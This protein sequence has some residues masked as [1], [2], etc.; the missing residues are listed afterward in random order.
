MPN[1]QA[2]V[3]ISG[4]NERE[5][6]VGPRP[7]ERSE[8][9][10]FFGRDREISELLSLVTSN[11]VVLCY[12]PSGAGKTSLINAGLHPR[13]ET[14]G[15]EVLPSTRVRGLLPEGVDQTS[16]ANIYIFNAVLS[17]AKETGSPDELAQ[18]TLAAYLST[19]PHLTDEEDFPSPRILIFDQF[20]ELLTSYLE[21]WQERD[22]FFHQVHAALQE[23]PLLRVLFVMR[24]D[25]VAR[26]EPF[27]RILKPLQQTRF[28]LDLLGPSGAQAAVTGPLRGT[29]RHFKPGVVDT[30][31][32]ELLKVRI[33]STAGEATE[34]IGEYVE[35][36]QLQV[37][38]RNLWTS[39][40]DEVQEISH[41]H[42]KAYG[43]VD[44]ALRE[45]YESCLTDA[46]TGLHTNEANLRQWF[47][48]QLITPAGTRGIVFRDAQQTAG[49]T[50]QVVDFLENRHII[51]GEW[52]AGSRWYELTH[53][54]LIKPIQHAN[55]RWRA[56]RQANRNRML[57]FAGVAMALV[58]M[59]FAATL[60]FRRGTA[61]AVPTNSTFVA[62]AN[63]NATS[64]V[65]AQSTTVAIESTSVAV[66]A[67]A[68]LSKSR[69]LAAE[70][71]LA[72]DRNLSLLLAIEANRRDDTLEARRSLHKVLSRQSYIDG[73]FLREL[74]SEVIAPILSQRL[75]DHQGPVVSV[76]FS[77]DSAR[78]VSGSG[79]GTLLV[80]DVASTETIGSPLTT[81]SSS[82]ESVA[83]SPN[84]RFVA[85]AGQDLQISL[86][87]AVTG[88]PVGRPMTGH[89]D[90]ITCLAFSPNGKLLASGSMDRHIFIWEV[91][92][93][94][95]VTKLKDVDTIASL[96]WSPDGRI[97]AA[98]TFGPTV[99]FWATDVW[100]FEDAL[101]GFSNP[102]RSMAWSPDGKLLALGLGSDDN[103]PAS[104]D[105]IL[106]DFENRQE[107][108]YSLPNLIQLFKTVGFR[109]IGEIAS[110]DW[111]E[112]STIDNTH[113]VRA[114]AFHPAGKILA[115]GRDDGTITFWDVQRGQILGTPLR[116]HD[117]WVMSIDFSP[118]GL[119]MLSG[120]IDRTVALWNLLAST[121]TVAVSPTGDLLAASQGSVIS[122][123]ETIGNS[124][125]P[126]KILS[127]H[128]A[129]VL[130]LAF[131]PDGNTLASSG[132]DNTI[133]LWNVQ[134]GLQI[135]AAL[136]TRSL[137]PTLQFNP[138]G[139]SLAL[140]GE[141]GRV[142]LMDLTTRIHQT[143]REQ[144][145]P[146]LKVQFTDGGNALQVVGKDGSLILFDWQT[147]TPQISMLPGTYRE[148]ISTAFSENGQK[149]A[150]FQV[151]GTGETA[152]LSD[153]DRAHGII[154]SY[155]D[156]SFDP[157]VNRE[158]ID[159]VIFK[160]TEGNQ[161]VDSTFEEYVRAS[162][163]IPMRGAFHFYRENLPWKEQA[164][165]F[166]S[167][168]DGQ[169]LHFYI[170][171]VE[172]L[173]QDGSTDFLADAE[174][175]LKYVDE[176]V[177]GRVML[178]TYNSYQEKLGTAGDWM[179]DWP[180]LILDYPTTPDR[181]GNPSLPR[182]FQDWHIWNY[183][184]K[185]EGA[186]YGV[187]ADRI[188]LAV[189]NGTPAE[190]GQ[191]LG[192]NAFTI[193]DRTSNDVINPKE[194]VQ[195]TSPNGLAFSPDDAYLAAAGRNTV[196][197]LNAASGDAISSLSVSG[198][199]L[200]MAF[201]PD[202][203]H[204]VIGTNYGT[205][206]VW[207]LSL[208]RSETDVEPVLAIACSQ[209]RANL[210]QA[211]WTQY[212]GVDVPYQATCSELPVP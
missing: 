35:P 69:Q 98:G 37:V 122:L 160:A 120:S 50:N 196:S 61:Y 30:L 139:S 152:V 76:A 129:N 71:L 165:L 171:D 93:G 47:E 149:I 59:L 27:M 136:S 22:G 175:W 81:N 144:S 10:L 191:W 90:L 146:V 49:L 194:A 54:R 159:F 197:L 209:V 201:T 9:N 87:D 12:A 63:E 189:F 97:L 157:S 33:E 2:E 79:N 34:V 67:D 25:F 163:S 44:Q 187:A 188:S 74:R 29:A 23:D 119:Y 36:V 102:I 150:Y 135:G 190:M 178:L 108:R 162:R 7:F 101:S 125:E 118:N 116:A 15:F 52:R 82:I 4:V 195:V 104:G 68:S 92:S 106:W 45:F 168:V 43:D 70:A 123:W 48:R 96:A 210:S 154:L 11:R 164:D 177:E 170:L 115:I 77:P 24:E 53:D 6:F 94:Q 100:D 95:L 182:G 199:I 111:P 143:L 206:L 5:V 88:A 46:R 75:P 117:H 42:L 32:E 155:W 137:V 198:E 57:G 185:G 26:I 64:V 8:Q 133:R 91:E 83:Y 147:G 142:Q 62:V 211:E 181:N 173:P 172:V 161:Y 89:E 55:E 41:E 31:I 56:Q 208:L 132:M 13:L 1:H 28:R 141:S 78:F 179:K 167:T 66:Q 151:G 176:Q 200:S 127:G 192:L 156:Q 110:G 126:V 51:R 203:D 107:V 113:R 58:L 134:E 121:S 174:Q 21:R 169:D 138:N 17:L 212:V 140:A 184:D 112:G 99:S 72:N 183:T 16:I 153:D 128:T 105:M 114:I 130:A 20:E 65:E 40:P 3:T 86:W 80:W 38:C 14:D 18:S 84:G 39:L 109:S 73:T 19:V 180:L 207:D 124:T 103:A 204:L 60:S 166:L 186:E 145:A 131:S 85:S 158:D 202:S 148:L 205:V 193:L